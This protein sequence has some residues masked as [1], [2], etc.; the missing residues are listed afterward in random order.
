MKH[1]FSKISFINL[2]SDNNK[3]L[4]SFYKN[5]V[6]LDVLP[7]QNENKSWFGFNT[8]GVT[9]AIEPAKNRENYSFRVK[10]N[11]VLIQFCAES[12]EELEEMNNQLELNGVKLLNRSKKMSYGT[13]TNFLDPDGNLL[14]ILL[15]D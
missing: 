12:I 15:A 2:Y 14:E 9:F 11:Q 7:D 4:I 5:V 1:L 8:S 6:G 13:S 10:D 3:K